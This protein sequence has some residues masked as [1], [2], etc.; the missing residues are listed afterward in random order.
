MD[1]TLRPLVGEH[2]RQ[3]GLRSFCVRLSA[4]SRSSSLVDMLSW[5]RLRV[6]W[7]AMTQNISL[8][9][10]TR[11]ALSKCANPHSCLCVTQTYTDSIIIPIP[12][13]A[14]SR[15]IIPATDRSS[16]CRCL[17]GAQMHLLDPVLLPLSYPWETSAMLNFTGRK[18]LVPAAPSISTVRSPLHPSVYFL[19]QT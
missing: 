3:S 14:F 6:P 9:L 4:W 7:A 13:H 11:F 18:C 12:S 16:R 10:R 15:I 2:E 8:Q 5:Q 17:D 1:F 19:A